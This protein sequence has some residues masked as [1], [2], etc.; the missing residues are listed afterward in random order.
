MSN[1]EQEHSGKDFEAPIVLSPSPRSKRASRR[2]GQNAKKQQKPA[3]D[4]TFRKPPRPPSPKVKKS[5]T[6]PFVMPPQLSPRPEGRPSNGSERSPQDVPSLCAADL[7]TIKAK[8]NL[9]FNIP[10]SS[11]ALSS[12]PSFEFDVDDSKSSSLSSAPEVEELDAEQFHQEFLKDHPPSSPKTQ[13][14]ICKDP[15]SRLFMEESV[16]TGVLTVRQQQKFCK[17]HKFRS[18]EDEWRTKG[19]PKID[20]PRFAERLTEYDTILSG[21]LNGTQS[22]FYKNAFEDQMKAGGNRTLQQALMSGNDCEG[23]NMGYYGTKGARIMY[24][25]FLL[26]WRLLR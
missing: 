20:W 12:G 7:E 8:L 13:C 24:T 17:A 10:P 22:S 14:P 3:Q 4:Q 11:A 18:A 6:P 1:A 23:L 25:P 19:Y 9:D 21:I 2:S 26:P 16:G 15:V 5:C